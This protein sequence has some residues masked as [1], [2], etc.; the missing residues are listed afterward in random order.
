MAVSVG[1]VTYNVLS[2]HLADPERFSHCKSNDLNAS[3]RL[4]RVIS[5]LEEHTS[6]GA[7]ICLQEVSRDWSGKLH[8]FFQPKGYTFVTSLY[9]GS[10]S[11]Y[12][13]VAIAFPNNRW[14]L[15]DA[16]IRR[17][18]DT[19]QW[20]S[21]ETN[22][23]VV[24]TRPGDWT[25]P[26]CQAN[27][28]ASR[29]ECFKC[30]APKPGS[31]GLGWLR[32]RLGTCLCFSGFQPRHRPEQPEQ[33]AKFQYLAQARRRENTLVA[34]HLQS[35]IHKNQSVWVGC[36]HMPCAYQE[37]QLM[38]MHAALAAQHVQRL[39][40]AS[41]APCVLAGDWNIKPGSEAYQLLTT[42]D[43]SQDSSAFPCVPYKDN[44]VP[45]LQFP[46]RSAYRVHH[47][48][49]PDFTN[50]AQILEEEPF[51]E[52]LDYIFCS[53]QLSVCDVPE[54]PHRDG[55]AGPLPSASEPSDHILVAAHL[56]LPTSCAETTAVV[57]QGKVAT[58]V[59]T[60]KESQDR[61]RQELYNQLLS[62]KTS[63]D[64]EMCF[65]PTLGGYERRLVHMI[66]GELE[67]EHNSFGEG[68][69]RHIKINK[70]TCFA[71]LVRLASEE[72]AS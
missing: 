15:M 29:T 40:I 65:P 42:G 34:V 49:E 70:Q 58:K 1:V 30:R 64:T 24:K 53:P 52:T 14:C 22:A 9:A 7:I 31:G 35:T 57:Y 67:L 8:V 71:D 10:F 47:G 59:E 46:M 11:G 44:W 3:T 33:P 50:Y 16:D 54:L 38:V 2:S 27:V 26:E 21:E 32:A 63:E 62:F 36:Y 28:F 18:S 43:L 68:A 17:V 56:E 69:E 5:K 37:P 41:Q 72:V 6:A 19:K 20:P 51:I 60:R 23:R 55:I 12:M 48:C 13:G 66:A 45:R 25:C 39:A 61:L 4:E